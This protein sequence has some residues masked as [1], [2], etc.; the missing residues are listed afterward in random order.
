MEPV[1]AGVVDG[2]QCENVA[3]TEDERLNEDEIKGNC[4][5]KVK[6]SENTEKSDNET[7]QQN[8]ESGKDTTE[9]SCTH[10]GPEKMTPSGVSHKFTDEKSKAEYL[11]IKS[12]VTGGAET[13]ESEGETDKTPEHHGSHH[14]PDAETRAEYRKI[15]FEVTGEAETSES[16]DGDN[17]AMPGLIDDTKSV[18]QVQVYEKSKEVNEE[19]WTDIL[20]NGLLKKKVLRAGKGRDT[21]PDRGQVVMLRTAGHLD[22]GTGADWNQC[23][24]FILGDGEVIQAFDLAVALMEVEE[25]CELVTD[26]KYA[27]G[28]F[29]RKECT[30]PVPPNAKITYELELMAV[31]DGPDLELMEDEERIKIGDKKRELG[32]ELYTQGDYSA[33]I[34]SY[35]RAL[36]YLSPSTSENVQSVKVKCW[37]NLAAAQLKI[38]AYNA[39]LISCMQVLQIDPDNVKALFRK[40]KVLASKGEL[41]EA[42][43]L[44]KKANQLDPNNKTIRAELRSLR[45]RKSIQDEKE[46]SMYQRMVGGMGKTEESK[47]SRGLMAWSLVLGA[48]VA[49][50]SGILA[51][52]Y[53]ARH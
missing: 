27:Y 23:L 18:S 8:K 26:P 17:S 36:K 47:D 33:A 39:A 25:V 22:D 41:S 10:A 51:A 5:D 31:S 9:N 40:G 19:E 13:S 50:L 16:D 48:T 53:F 1:M 24:Q 43:P 46:R 49:A 34:N 29:G 44:I 7:E 35:Q 15:K 38:E 4:D 30:P 12:E 28:E 21:R 37:N 6:F 14:S 32:N 45:K 2:K 20:G 3:T 11:K 52:I 42:L